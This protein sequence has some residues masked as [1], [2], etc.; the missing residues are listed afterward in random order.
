M[1]RRKRSPSASALKQRCERQFHTL[2]DSIPQLV[3]M[4]DSVGKIYWFNNHWHEYTGTSV[5]DTGSHDWQAILV[6]AS[7]EEARRRWAQTLEAGT[8]P[9]MELSLLGKEGQYRPFLT[10]VIPLRDPSTMIY[11]WI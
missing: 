1:S 11:G 7:L 3:W 9:E 10:R 8:A 4:A 6:P 2:A 5:G